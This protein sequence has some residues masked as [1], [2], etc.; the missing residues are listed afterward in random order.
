MNHAVPRSLIH[1]DDDPALLR[2]VSHRLKPH[3]ITVHSINDPTVAVDAVLTRNCRLVLLDIDMPKVNGIELLRQIKQADGGVQAIM[4]T[5]I[6]SLSSAMEAYRVGAE[7]CFFKPLEKIEPL[8]DAITDTFRKIDR[9]WE[10]M[11][12][13]SQQLRNSRL[14]SEPVGAS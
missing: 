6:V 8:V 7:A 12:R 3:G 14:S 1:V 11:N 10:T 2:L 5:G 13:L 9:W 4:L